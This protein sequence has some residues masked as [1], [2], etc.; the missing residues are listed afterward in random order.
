MDED[1]NEPLTPEELQY[2]LLECAR[3]GEDDDLRAILQ[4]NIPVNFQDENGNTALHRAAANG[5]VACLKTLKDFGATF[6]PN[7]Q[8]NTPLHWA[9][10]NGQAEAIRFILDNFNVDV[11]EKN[12]CGRSALTEAFSSKNTDCI[13]HCLSHPSASEERLLPGGSQKADDS[14]D[15]MPPVPETSEEVDTEGADSPLK[16]AVTHQMQFTDSGSVVK[17]RE[18]PITR[19]DHPFGSEEAPE[20]DTTGLGV[21]PASV[22]LAQWVARA[23][24]DASGMRDLVVVEL[25]AGCGLPALVAAAYCPC[26][27]VY[28][29]DIHAPTLEN[30]QFNVDLN[31]DLFAQRGVQVQVSNVN[32]KDEASYPASKADILLGSDLVYDAAILGLLVRAVAGMLKPGGVFL[33]VAPDSGRDGLSDLI[34]AL[35][36]AG[37]DCVDKAPASEE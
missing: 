33:Y 5:H 34:S 27:E 28:I 25:G 20:D 21:W 7:Q 8:G 37:I 15:P 31:A 29:T 24:G 9:A 19:A 14:Q 10:Q 6:L 12:A 1:H 22:L 18:L 17:V 3:Y 13:E 4:A 26:K 2:E 30:A 11:L 23:C 16:N 36:A 32:W 35:A